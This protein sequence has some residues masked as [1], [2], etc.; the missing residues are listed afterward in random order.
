M[1]ATALRS[2]TVRRRR[3]QVVPCA[4]AREALSARADQEASTISAQVLSGHLENCPPCRELAGQIAALGRPW[5]VRARKDTPVGLMPLLL[6]LLGS[7]HPRAVLLRRVRS[8]VQSELYG[9]RPMRWLTAAVPVVVVSVA[10][11]AG[12]GEHP[13]LVPTRPASPC[14]VGLSHHG[15]HTSRARPL[16]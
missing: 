11:S 7:A 8:A 1:S 6:P 9:A 13:H 10:L 14:T 3:G 2:K 5:G 15:A 12:L 16:R 4:A